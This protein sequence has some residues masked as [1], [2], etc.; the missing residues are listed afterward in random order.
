MKRAKGQGLPGRVLT[1]LILLIGLGSLGARVPSSFAKPLPAKPQAAASANDSQESQAFLSNLRARVLNN[2][3]LPDG[4]NVVVLEATIT[5]NGDVLEVK[6]SDSRADS[7]AIEAATSAF[8]KAQ[9]VGH[10][11]MKYHSDCKLTLTFNSK[12]DPH[13]DST[14]DLNSRLDPISQPG[15]QGK[16]PTANQSS[17]PQGQGDVSNTGTESTTSK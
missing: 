1:V 8:E 5:P 16:A 4:N 17:Q 14:S 11:P 12:V 9:P 6:T 7:L 10:L 3:L 15:T 2:W 13:G